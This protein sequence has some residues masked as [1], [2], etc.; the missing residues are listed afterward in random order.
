MK[1]TSGL[2]KLLAVSLLFVVLTAGF[3]MGL[4]WDRGEANAAT[5]A[6][7]P[8][9]EDRP[10]RA[11][12]IDEVGLETA[13]R[14]EVDE[15]IHHFRAQMRA[16]DKEFRETYRPRQRALL[17]QTRD[18]IKATLSP[19]QRVV[20]DSLLDARYG[21]SD[22]DDRPRRRR[23]ESDGDRGRGGWE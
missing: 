19:A 9:P 22:Q 13:Q 14:A 4:A 1:G 3:M 16:L 21:G 8:E 17:G 2:T 18:S 5:A 11:L 6:V 10:R 15:I 7:G 23:R 20:Y 12:V